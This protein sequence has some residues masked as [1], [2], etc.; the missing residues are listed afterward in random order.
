[1]RLPKARSAVVKRKRCSRGLV[2]AEGRISETKTADLS[3]SELS[4]PY[5]VRMIK[6]C[7]TCTVL[8]HITEVNINPF[9]VYL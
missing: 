5:F 1:M 9:A 3:H 6:C 4:T 2:V 7:A 8:R